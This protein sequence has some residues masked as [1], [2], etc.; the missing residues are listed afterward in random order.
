MIFV[1]VGTS[2]PFDRLIRALDEIV[3][4]GIFTEEIFAQVGK[5]GYRPSHF[6]WV[7]TL[8]KQEFDA[9]FNQAESLIAHAGM[10]TI[11]MALQ[12]HKPILVI[13]RLKQFKE[14]VNDHQ[15]ATA[16]QFERSGHVLAAYHVD[17]LLLKIQSL[18]TFHPA[19]RK[20]QAEQVS[21]YIGNFLQIFS[22]EK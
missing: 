16:K 12:Q 10:G 13:P 1:T 7:E 22:N 21:K 8:T 2:F 11:T 20:N 18:K 4:Q 3:E 6:N 14:L 17:E 15:L 9:Y 5:G 19:P